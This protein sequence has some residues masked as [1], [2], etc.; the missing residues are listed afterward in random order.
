MIKGCIG[1]ADQVD[2]IGCIGWIKSG[3]HTGCHED[4]MSLDEEGFRQLVE[5]RAGK[6]VD[7]RAIIRVDI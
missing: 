5:K 4:L 7:G 2:D 1:V 3:T 6:L